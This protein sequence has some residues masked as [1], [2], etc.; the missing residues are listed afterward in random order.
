MPKAS[1]GEL[2]ER[3]GFR[4][5]RHHRYLIERENNEIFSKTLSKEGG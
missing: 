4:S 3:Q 2:T 5:D 1:L